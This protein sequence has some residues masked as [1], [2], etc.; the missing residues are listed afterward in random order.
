MKFKEMTGVLRERVVRTPSVESFRFDFPGKFDFSPGQFGEVIFDPDDRKNRD[1]NKFL[2]FS[3]APERD[4]VEVTK[5]LS[6]SDFSGRLKG[7]RPGDEVLLR[8]PMGEC[9]Y[10]DE[11]R[12]IAFL[13]GGIGITPVASI[14]DHIAALKKD[15]EVM[16]FYS[17]KSEDEIAFEKEF[18]EWAAEG[19]RISLF[20]FVTRV[21]PV[22]KRHYFGRLNGDFI[23]EQVKDPAEWFFFTFGPPKMVG[24]MV[25]LCRGLGCPEDQLKAEKFAGYE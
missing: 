11:Y 14:V 13:A 19:E 1:L 9:N 17:N 6:G 8:G 16:I 3:S 12:K 2:S 22:D 24:A 15:T 23:L 5:R 7:L 20:S 21:E 4:Y 25:E 18:D 10:R